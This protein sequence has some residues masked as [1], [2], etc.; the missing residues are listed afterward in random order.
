MS[1]NTKADDQMSRLQI[2]EKTKKMP[3][4][5]LNSDKI[6][7][8]M[9]NRLK[10]KII[11]EQIK[12][13][14][15]MKDNAFDCSNDKQIDEEEQESIRE[16]KKYEEE[17]NS[18][19]EAEFQIKKI[20]DIKF[21]ECIISK[22]N[23]AAQIINDDKDTNI[24]PFTVQA[25]NNNKLKNYNDIFNRFSIGKL[26]NHEILG[27]GINP[28]I[29]IKAFYK[30]LDCFIRMQKEKFF[31]ENYNNQILFDKFTYCINEKSIDLK[32]NKLKDLFN[33]EINT[34]NELFRVLLLKLEAYIEASTFLNSYFALE[35]SLMSDRFKINFDFKIFILKLFIQHYITRNPIIHVIVR[36]VYEFSCFFNGFFNFEQVFSLAEI[37]KENFNF[38]EHYTT[39]K[40]NSKCMANNEEEDLNISNQVANNDFIW[41]KSLENKLKIIEKKDL[42]DLS[43]LENNIAD[44]SLKAEIDNDIDEGEEIPILSQLIM[45]D[46][47]FP[48]DEKVSSNNPPSFSKNFIKEAFGIQNQA[49]ENRSNNVKTLTGR[50]GLKVYIDDNSTKNYRQLYRSKISKKHSDEKNAVIEENQS[51]N[52]INIKTIYKLLIERSNKRLTGEKC[53]NTSCSG[54]F[55]SFNPCDLNAENVINHQVFNNPF[56]SSSSKPH[57][58]Q[59]GNDILSSYLPSGNNQPLLKNRDSI[60]NKTKELLLSLSK[61]EKEDERIVSKDINELLDFINSDLPLQNKE[62]QCAKKKKKNKKKKEKEKDFVTSVDFITTAASLKENQ[63][64]NQNGTGTGNKKKNEITQF[65]SVDKATPEDD[66]NVE[67]FKISLLNNSVHASFV[68]K[69][70][71][72]LTNINLLK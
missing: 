12:A 36:E 37:F 43:L 23:P 32:F 68:H 66:K 39:N 70:K 16:K 54:K 53:I 8:L 47:M 58:I 20:I 10:Q 49:R 13:I 24:N 42:N 48:I 22:T 31:E 7:D 52:S 3:L 35:I 46:E 15:N 55:N 44:S 30:T 69:I 40:E 56:I 50:N 2:F 14:F 9:K 25:N 29:L 72:I 63:N 17:L 19:R 61:A 1:T 62:D 38:I 59:N 4:G 64:G 6:K 33:S 57:D 51:D 5:G 41:E 67:Q 65:N 34:L 45:K 27:T 26:E 21:K 11:E 60:N 18:I 28:E 71:I